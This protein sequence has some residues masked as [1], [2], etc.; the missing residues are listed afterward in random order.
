MSTE[1]R[2]WSPFSML[3]DDRIDS[4]TMVRGEGAYIYDSAGT[5]YLDGTSGLWYTLIGHGRHDMA[6][7]VAD[8]IRTLAA[9][10]T[11]GDYDNLPARALSRKVIEKLPVADPL[12][13]FTTGGGDAIETACKMA[14]SYWAVTGRPDKRVFISRAGA[15][16][17]MNGFGT[18]V[19]GIPALRSGFEDGFAADCVPVN[20]P[21]ALA[22]RIEDIG[23]DRVAAFLAEPV[24]GA[25]GVI[26]PAEGYFDEVQAICHKYDVLLIV[27]EIVTAFGRLGTWSGS[28]MFDIRPDIVAL[29]KG[30]TSGY[31]PLG[32]TVAA[33]RVWQ[34]FEDEKAVFRH[35]YTYSG[36]PTA[37]AAALKNIQI[38][39]DERLPE[40]AAELAPSF[41]AALRALAADPLVTQVRAIGLM[42]GI[43]L[44]HA[45]AERRG[46]DAGEEIVRRCRAN[47]VIVRRM[48]QGDI[49]ITPPLVIDDEDV[50]FLATAVGAAIGE[51]SR[52]LG[53]S[54]GRPGG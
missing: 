54:G 53:L 45:A 8:Q 17:G 25:G 1:S 48:F 38:L 47:G 19:V 35:G 31:V 44:D 33:N 40:R 6:D 32:A 30:I 18:G 28:Q 27:D 37:C 42:A 34:A 51:L 3:P 26:P 7:A 24:I 22:E 16:H 43:G 20:D 12:V 46:M 10:K 49:Q 14:R 41:A 5:K 36:H 50:K 29:A 2:L 23:A 15:Y 11:H 13:F 39:E 4:V 52:D 9:F 21:A